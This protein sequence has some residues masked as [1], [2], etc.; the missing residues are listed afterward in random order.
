M[1][2]EPL[3]EVYFKWLYSK[4][5]ST[6]NPTPSLMFYTLFRDLH[7]TE[8]VWLVTGDDN[9]AQDGLDVRREFIRES[10]LH[11]EPAWNNLG[12]SVLEMFIAFTRRAEFET[13]TDARTWFWIFLENLGLADLSDATPNVSQKVQEVMDTFIW[14][15]YHRNGQGG[16]FPL[17]KPK[18][19]QTEVE[20]WQQLSA[21]LVENEQF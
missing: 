19:N 9:R 3:E 21:Y 12:C 17:R 15:T 4:V 11:Q 6:A 16:M 2:N 20:L 10:F 13:D 1:L 14:R 7:T 8:F 5:A 18:R